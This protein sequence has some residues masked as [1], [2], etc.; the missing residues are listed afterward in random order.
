MLKK[1]ANLMRKPALEAGGYAM[2]E[3]IR[4]YA[5][6]DIHGRLDLLEQMMT[7][8]ERDVAVNTTQNVIKIVF[9]GDYIDR[10][11]QSCAV[12]ERLIQI[13]QHSPH[14]ICLMGNHEEILLNI[15][16][17][18][19]DDKMIDSWLGYGG[20]ETLASYGISSRVLYSD[21][22]DDITQ[23]ARTSIPKAHAD[24]LASL[25]FNIG[26]GDYFF[27]HAG[28]HPARPLTEQ[29]T[30][31]FL[32]IREPFL[33]YTEPLEKM[34]IH[35]H[36]ISRA[37]EER[38]HRIGIDTGAYATGKLTAIILEN[39]TRRFIETSYAG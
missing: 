4:A 6:G 28:I 13:R 25:D 21:N 39:N 27:V 11:P 22:I 9:L 12:I 1:L 16:H 33:G 10:G 29:R 2:P 26:Y 34:I 14:V 23:A 3:G 31:D 19:S 24:F 18:R 5:I 32:W 38:V 36:S 35:G 7:H 15:I 17:G 37:V 20:R 30:Q 8:I